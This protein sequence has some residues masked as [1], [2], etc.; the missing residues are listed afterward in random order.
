[1]QTYV[2]GGAPIRFGILFKTT[3]E[4]QMSGLIRNKDQQNDEPISH[5]LIHIFY[6]LLAKYNSHRALLFLSAVLFLFFIF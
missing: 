6:H 1:M 3:E 2:S 5:L 4:N